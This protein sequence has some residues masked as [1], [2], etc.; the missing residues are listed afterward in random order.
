VVQQDVPGLDL[1]T[2]KDGGEADRAGEARTSEGSTPQQGLALGAADQWGEGMSES[3]SDF[4]LEFDGE[5]LVPRIT[6]IAYRQIYAL[7][8]WLR[9]ICLAA[10]MGRFGSKWDQ[11]LDTRLRNVLEARAQR[12][13]QRLYLGA[14]SHDDLIWEAT[15]AELLQLLVANSIRDSIRSLTGA[16]SRFLEAKLSEIREIRNLLAHNRALSR[17]TYVILMGLLASLEEAVNTFKARVLYG[18]PSSIATLDDDQDWSILEGNDLRLFQGFVDRRG[19]FIEYVSLPVARHGDWPDAR[20]LLRA[21]QRQLDG[22]IAFC[23]NKTGQEFIML[24][25]AILSQESQGALLD[26]FASNPD[27]WTDIPFEAQPP[28]FVCNPKI[29]FY[30]NQSPAEIERF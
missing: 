12:N 19:D 2:K 3:I 27:I 14:E 7:E 6:L 13:S 25:P 29:W 11:E 30:E 20:S 17:R 26:A 10:W 8:G 22:I 9:R 16:D 24:T 18:S 1:E 28:R 23:L 21:F 5:M 4:R 15:H